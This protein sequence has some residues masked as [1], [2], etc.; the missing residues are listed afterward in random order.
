MHTIIAIFHTP[1]EAQRAV[2]MVRDSH[3]SLEDVSMISR[4]A[5]HGVAVEGSDDD[6]AS[7]GAT[8][9][10]VWGGMV[11]IASLVIPGVG[12]IIAA[13]TLATLVASAI[14][15]ALTGA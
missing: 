2:E 1:Q 14:T 9:G 11:G 6:S 12:P 7:E 8:V 5:E 4:A 15:G 3:V 10:A 13:G